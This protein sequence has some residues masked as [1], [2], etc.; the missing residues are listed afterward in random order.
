MPLR[1]SPST[2][3][4]WLN[5]S[6]CVDASKDI[7]DQPSGKHAIEGTAAHELAAMCLTKNVNADTF[8]GEKIEVEDSKVKV[9]A[10]MAAHIQGYLDMC[11]ELSKNALPHIEVKVEMEYAKGT[12]DFCAVKPLDIVHV[13]DLKYG[14]SE[15]ETKDN[16]QMMLYALAMLRLYDADR[17]SI[18][19]YQPRGNSEFTVCEYSKDELEAFEKTVLAAIAKTKSNPTDFNPGE[20]C[21]WCPAKLT[22]RGIRKEIKETAVAIT[23]AFADAFPVVTTLSPAQLGAVLRFNEQFKQL[24]K[25]CYDYALNS[26]ADI[27]GYKRVQK[28]KHRAWIDEVA[29]ET[30]LEGEFGDE[31]YEKKL[32]SPAQMEKIVGKDRVKDLVHIPE[33][34][35]TLVADDG[36][37]ERGVTTEFKPV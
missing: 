29:V 25:A 7:P 4:I 30:E 34:D 1:L 15:V 13:R 8:I 14:R 3:H 19:I 23:P 18:G 35:M 16:P 9:T 12:V 10:T 36:R 21:H 5:C 33:G 17:A 31:V 37:D 28:K 11:R 20:H 22:C 6:A 24:Y 2:A 32:K 26:G 27:P